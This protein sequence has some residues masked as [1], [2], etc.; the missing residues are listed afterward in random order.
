MCD[1]AHR[2]VALPSSTDLARARDVVSRH[3]AP[4]PLVDSPL[5]GGRLKLETLQPTGAFKVRGALAALSRLPP[6]ARAVT[7]SA[8]NHGLGMAWASRTLGVPATVV[9]P[10]TGS[11]AKL[12]ALR[13]LGADLRLHGSSYDEAEAFALTLEGTY[14]SA[15]NDRDVIAGQA[16][17]GA[18]LPAGPVC[19]VAPAGGGGLL[20]GLALWAGARGE[21][22]V[23]GVE[24][25]ASRALS[26]AVTAGRVVPVGVGD[27]LADGLA[28][29]L[30]PGSATVAGVAGVPIVAVTEA[31]IAEAMRALARA[32]G[33]VAEGAAAAGVAAVLSG[34]VSVTDREALVVALTG[35][36][37]ALDVLAEVL[38]GV[39]HAP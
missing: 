11:P 33:L 17:L 32:H 6:G 19:V 1:V 30:E 38:S 26:A 37:V 16:T 9:V 28:G 8:G 18:E 22:R 14:V 10:E 25:A 7:A 5:V 20:S 2:R 31:E 12:A 23:V 39:R 29:N 24:A 36:N 13:A 3:L 35:R 27:T 34:G 15:Y 21:A 4:T